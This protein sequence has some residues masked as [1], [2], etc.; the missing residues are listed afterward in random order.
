MRCRPPV[1]VSV[2]TCLLSRELHLGTTPMA[3]SS[4]WYQGSREQFLAESSDEIADLLAGR[5]VRESLE[6]QPAQATEWR[7]SVSLLQQHLNER[8][9]IVRAA[10]TAPGAEAISHVILEYD[11]RRRGLRID[12]LLLAAGVLFVVEF[13]RSRIEG[14]DRDQV[15]RYAVN[16]LEFH[17]ETRRWC[18][19]DR[20]IVVPVIVLTEGTAAS[21]SDWPG[22]AGHSWPALARRP[23]EC[24][25]HS[26]G[27]AIVRTLAAR[28]SD[29]ATSM[30]RWITSEFRPSSSILDAALSLYGNHDVA[31]ISRHSA[32][33]EAI[34]ASTAEIHGEID[35]ALTE[36]RPHIVFLSGAPGAGKTLVGLDITLRG[37]H[38][39]DAVFVTGNAPLVEV[40]TEALKDSYRRTASKSTSWARTGYRRRDAS[41]VSGLAT[42]KIVKAHQFLGPRGVTHNQADGRVLVF[43]EAQRT[44][45]QGRRV[46]DRVLPEH[47][48]EL[49]L[50]AQERAYPDRATVVVAL[51]GHNQ[52]INRGER[53]IVA[54]LEA[55]ERHGW[56]FA[57]SDETLGLSE[58]ESRDSW[59]SHPLRRVLKNGH[60]S[61]SMRFYRNSA[62]EEWADAV[63]AGDTV[64]ATTHA[65][66]LVREGHP[67][68]LTRSLSAARHWAR[69]SCAG[70]ERVGLIASGQARRLAAEGLFVDQ[71]PSIAH[72]MLAPSG[73]IRSSNALETVQNQY[74]VQGLELDYC[75]V[76]WDADLRRDDAGWAAFRLS[77]SD[78][79]RDSFVDVAMNSYRVLLTRARKGMTIFVPYGDVGREDVTRAPEFYDGIA[80]FLFSCGAL[81]LPGEG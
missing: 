51:V 38:A 66:D 62:V 48:A 76:C 75:V 4:A 6:L 73:D 18:R 9:P 26:L 27:S 24:D 19:E 36:K 35:R 3:L 54:W 37:R 65:G 46:L 52:A 14:A 60:L 8:L 16:L 67:I 39:A 70:G 21:R 22:L 30:E 41:L 11:F 79:K 50:G 81:P 64:R 72:W 40:L 15:M 57:I 78:W 58:I 29:V 71:K 77:G 74:Q 13:K 10:L 23:I 12:C 42:F 32:S 44:Y 63:L 31:A 1:S 25:R 47:E 7:A 53:G 59:T 5:A 43:D 45:E 17:S 2:T 61:E 69:E 56:T 80:S 33:Q 34:A 28:R 55:A 49:I 68:R 20:A